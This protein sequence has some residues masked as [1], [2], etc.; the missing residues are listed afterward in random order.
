MKVRI[1]V[2]TKMG[3]KF[4]SPWIRKQK[5]EDYEHMI[6]L[7]KEIMEA[8]GDTRAGFNYRSPFFGRRAEIFLKV[9]EIDII[10]LESRGR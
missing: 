6:A 2:R 8:S 4:K 5:I 7:F 1:K 9:G 3:T 10:R